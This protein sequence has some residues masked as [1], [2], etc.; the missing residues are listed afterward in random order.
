MDDLIT[1]YDSLLEAE[2]R[3]DEIFSI[4]G[5]AGMTM[6]KWRISGMRE[7]EESEQILG[8]Q[9]PEKVLGVVWNIQQDVLTFDAKPLIE[10]VKSIKPTKFLPESARAFT[11]SI[12]LKINY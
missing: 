9:T 4:L 5:E 12:S 1:G 8:L 11:I 3:K 7:T 6:K 2:I 10:F